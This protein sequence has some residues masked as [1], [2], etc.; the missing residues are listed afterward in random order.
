MHSISWGYEKRTQPARIAGI[1]R[2]Y[3][4]LSGPFSDDTTSMPSNLPA[5]LRTRFFEHSPAV[6]PSTD[7]IFIPAD[8]SATH[9]PDHRAS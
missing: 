4:L 5:A 3:R 6:L 9:P 1:L 8:P 2:T 7:I